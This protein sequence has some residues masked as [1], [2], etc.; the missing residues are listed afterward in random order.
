LGK[1]FAYGTLTV[2]LVGCFLLG[3]VLR[4]AVAPTDAA[5]VLRVGVGIGF[6]G[7][8]TTFSTFGVDTLLLLEKQRPLAAAVYVAANVVCGLACV[9]AGGRLGQ[10]LTQSP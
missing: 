10:M 2:N 8:F 5:H 6:L 3:C 1:E 7:A 4:F 9:W